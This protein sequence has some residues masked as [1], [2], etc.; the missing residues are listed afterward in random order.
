MAR[1][2]AIPIGGG[3]LSD[4][5]TVNRQHVDR[6]FAAGL[7]DHCARFL[8]S[9]PHMRFICESCGY[10]YDPAEGDVDGGI[11]PGTQ[12]EDIPETWFCPVCG[13]S[14]RDFLPYEG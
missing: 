6:V 3:K 8:Y 11:P 2:T 4:E 1:A 10:I 12:F 14:K 9:Q 7:P 5:R 13:V